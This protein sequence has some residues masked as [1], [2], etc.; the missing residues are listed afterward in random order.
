MAGPTL[1]FEIDSG[2]LARTSDTIA[3]AYLKAGKDTIAAVTKGLERDLEEL[4]K[5]E[6]PGR[7]WRAWKSD[8][9]PRGN[10]IAKDPAGVVFVN[11][12]QRSQGAM[13]FWSQP[14]RIAGKSGQWLAIPLPAAG[15]RGRTRDLTPGEWERRTGKRLRFVY[16]GGR[17][18]ALLVAD[19]GTTNARTGAFRPITRGRTAADQRRGFMRGEQSVPIFVLV[20]TVAFGNRVAVQPQIDKARGRLGAEFSSRVGRF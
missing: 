16:R 5:A 10:A 15:S 11:G 17:R 8:V 13:T 3:R 6:V 14:G 19:M 12:G 7:L 2:A 1:G 18:S 9:F 4:T 20:P